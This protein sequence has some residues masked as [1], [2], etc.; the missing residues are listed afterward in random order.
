MFCRFCGNQV[1]DEAYVCPFCRRELKEIPTEIT[2]P[3]VR[4]ERPRKPRGKAKLQRLCRTFSTLGIAFNA[5]GFGLMI[6][7]VLGWVLL[8]IGTSQPVYNEAMETCMMLATI[9]CGYFGFIFGIIFVGLGAD[10]STGAFILGLIQKEDKELKRR[11][12]GVFIGGM[13]L[14]VIWIFSFM[15]SIVFLSVAGASV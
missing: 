7:Q 14:L 5:A 4:V 9:F 6:L 2:M 15:F 10:F 8:F 12:I 11:A 13:A 3:H 1:R